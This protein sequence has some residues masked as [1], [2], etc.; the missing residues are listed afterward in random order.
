MNADGLPIKISSTTEAEEYQSIHRKA[1]ALANNHRPNLENCKAIRI[2][3]RTILF[4]KKNLSE[5]KC[6]YILQAYIENKKTL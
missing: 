3:S 5:D 6:N 2:D 4:L 1:I